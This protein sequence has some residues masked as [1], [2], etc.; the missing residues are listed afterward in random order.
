MKKSKTL[1]QYLFNV[2]LFFIVLFLAAS[3]A[4]LGTLSMTMKNS[5]VQMNSLSAMLVS[6]RLEEFFARVQDSTQHVA[7]LLQRPDIYQALHLQEYLDDALHEFPYLDRIEIV[8]SDC[9]IRAVSPAESERIGVSR[10]GERVFTAVRDSGSSYWSD[11][12]ISL[13]DSQP[14][15]T[16]GIVIGEYVIFFDLSLRWFRDFASTILS[17][18]E[19]DLSIRLTD[20]NGVFI[21]HPDMTQVLQRDRQAEF[22]RIRD[23]F[24]PLSS[25]WVREGAT[26]LLVSTQRLKEPDWYVHVLYP[27]DTLYASLRNVIFGLSWLSACS[28]LLG[29]YFWRLR[30]RRIDRAFT[31][32]SAEAGRIANGDYG[33]LAGFGEGFSE[34]ETVGQSLER[35]VGAIGTREK[36][37]KDRERGFREIQDSLDL[38]AITLDTEGV[39]RYAN[40]HALALLG[41]LPEEIVGGLFS[42]FIC[43]TPADCPFLPVLAAERSSVRVQSNLRTKRG[44]ERIID[45]SIVKIL[46]A[47]G[48]LA[49]ATG[50]GHDNTE[51]IQTRESI[52]RSLKEKDILLREVHHRVKNNLQVITSLL[53]IQQLDT[54]N[55]EVLVALMEAGARIHSIALV[56]ELLYD[57]DDFG[58][59]DFREYSEALVRNL[60][61]TQIGAPVEYQIDLGCFSL[62]LTEAVPCGLVLNEAVINSM[63]HAFHDGV[64]GTPR[65]VVSGGMQSDGLARIVIRD[66]G[67]GIVEEPESRPGKHLGLTIMKVLAEQLHGTLRIYPD[68]GTVV[69]LTFS[70]GTTKQAVPGTP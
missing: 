51:M 53:S 4:S 12:Y 55:P 6:S 38:V 44:E 29:V 52:E 7:S 32:I 42:N 3:F 1:S 18:P 57:S 68:G 5:F 26:I 39:I 19:Q 47:S 23:H 40:P 16:Y 20:H 31:A 67:V 43:G 35:M 49:G 46:D 70:P 21:Y 41:Y 34:F 37:L 17:S 60:L 54:G 61:S 30:L 24:D 9:R 22:P 69:E 45:W 27:R 56:H 2:V 58:E 59:I 10:E 63:K 33:A 66:N 48:R 14:A 25:I 62:S 36:T 8:G 50:I 13:P 15:V 28:L 11:S 64:Q 65:I